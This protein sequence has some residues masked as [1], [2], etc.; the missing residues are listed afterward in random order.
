MDDK[1]KLELYQDLDKLKEKE[2]ALSDKLY[3]E[4]RVQIIVYAFTGMALVAVVGALL[5]YVIK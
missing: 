5:K 2:R 3:A 1:Q 4:K